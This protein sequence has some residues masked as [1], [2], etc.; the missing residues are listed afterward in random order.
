MASHTVPTFLT[1]P[2][3]HFY[4]FASHGAGSLD[5][6]IHTPGC[7]PSLLPFFTMLVISHDTF[8]AHTFLIYWALLAIPIC[9]YILLLILAFR[10]PMCILIELTCFEHF[11]FPFCFHIISARLD[12]QQN[13]QYSLDWSLTA[14]FMAVYS[15]METRI[16]LSSKIKTCICE[17]EQW[18][19]NAIVILL[20]IQI[21]SRRMPMSHSG[22]EFCGLTSQ[23]APPLNHTTVAAPQLS[24]RPVPCKWRATAV[25][26]SR[27]KNC[28][29]QIIRAILP[30]QQA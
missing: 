21:V 7:L 16:H 15:T 2:F 27:K 4:K 25:V 26:S 23:A 14:I 12:T 20:G 6:H 5:C 8:K 13:G 22:G 29:G 30:R 9:T 10:T 11:H 19:T 17:P 1:Q 3:S 24:G 28:R 18:K